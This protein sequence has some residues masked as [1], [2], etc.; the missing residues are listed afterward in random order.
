MCVLS[1]Q[2]LV[3]KGTTCI[4]VTIFKT[5]TPYPVMI[6]SHNLNAPYVFI[7]R[8]AIGEVSEGLLRFSEADSYIDL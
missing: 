7:D 8:F 5:N 1:L 2:T 6:R 4:Y 3:H